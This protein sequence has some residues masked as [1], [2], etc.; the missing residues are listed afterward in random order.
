MFIRYTFLAIVP[1]SDIS[2]LFMLWFHYHMI[3]L[4]VFFQ[5]PRDNLDPFRVSD[6]FKIW[7]V[8]EKCHVKDE[9]EAAGGLDV[10][11]KE[12]GMPFSVGQRQLLCLARALLKSTKV[13][14]F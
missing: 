2:V 6:D 4:T 7:K 9:V 13:M 3:T 14:F 12:A 5:I 11:V 10:H 8:L 1:F